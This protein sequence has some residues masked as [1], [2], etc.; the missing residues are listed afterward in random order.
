MAW[1]AL[2]GAV[3]RRA[4]RLLLLGGL[5]APPSLAA[6]DSP[7]ADMPRR[8]FTI[9]AGGSDSAAVD[10]A[11]ALCRLLARL[12]DEP[13]AGGQRP[14]RCALQPSGGGADSLAQLL[15]HRAAFALVPA[16]LAG[17]AHRGGQPDQVAHPD[18]RA[19]FALYAE[20]FN[21]VA[22][23]ETA[24]TGLAD[25]RG[26]RVG[27][28]SAATIHH[29]LATAV[30]AAA[31]IDVDDIGAAL[32][33][34]PGRQVGALCGGEIDAFAFVIPAP[35]VAVARATDGCGARL[36]PLPAAVVARVTAAIPGTVATVIAPASYATTTQAV[37]TVGVVVLLATD[38]G[39]DP[40]TVHA[41]TRAVIQ[42]LDE[43]R[44]QHPALAG[45]RPA[46]MIGDGVTLPLHP[47]ALRYYREQ[48]W[49]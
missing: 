25:L 23:R 11:G 26:R 48:G 5:L 34:P 8:F 40:D 37:P 27:L 44:G 20:P 45:L 33:L 4:I 10:T 2:I 13:T 39:A 18:L 3:G 46:Q 36:I 31:A 24:I 12:A 43:I 35:S 32:D 28:G 30:L 19:V 16:P 49:L 29:A 7:A 15:D 22:G 47:G 6:A 41:L 42:H 38:A 9:A 21:L 17:Q 1:S 14:P